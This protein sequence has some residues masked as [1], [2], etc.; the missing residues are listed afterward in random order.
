[1][2]ISAAVTITTETE[3]DGKKD[4]LKRSIKHDRQ[5]GKGKAT[6]AYE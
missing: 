3:D 5:P 2:K 6:P 1:M 4:A